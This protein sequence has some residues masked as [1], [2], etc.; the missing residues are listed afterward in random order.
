M[1][2]LVRPAENP[3]I[4]ALG[5]RK[6]DRFTGLTGTTLTLSNPCVL[7]TEQVFKNGTL[8]DPGNAS[9]YFIEASTVTLGVALVNTDVVVVHFNYRQAST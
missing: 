3:N 7:G 9:V 1:T 8:L 4:A 6:Y 2:L 5:N